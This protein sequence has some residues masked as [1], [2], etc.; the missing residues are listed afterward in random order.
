MEKAVKSAASIKQEYILA[1][2]M[3]PLVRKQK[4]FLSQDK[5]FKNTCRHFGYSHKK[6]ATLELNQE[7][8]YTKGLGL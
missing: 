6:I 1:G 3:M 2:T 7:S 4:Y 8:L 5:V